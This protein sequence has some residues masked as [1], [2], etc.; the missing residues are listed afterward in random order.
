MDF[1]N[2]KSFKF[3]IFI[4]SVLV[5]GFI[6]KFAGLDASQ[7]NIVKLSTFSLP[8]F[9]IF[10]ICVSWTYNSVHFLANHFSQKR[11]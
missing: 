7:A 5:S 3:V 8:I 11:A 2:S 6:L 4:L 1:N 9:I 10:G